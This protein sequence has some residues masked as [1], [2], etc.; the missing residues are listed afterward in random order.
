[1]WSV[2]DIAGAFFNAD[3]ANLPPLLQINKATIINLAFEQ[4]AAV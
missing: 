2:N 1:M 4:L 3:I